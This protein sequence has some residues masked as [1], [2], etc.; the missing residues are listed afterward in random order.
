MLAEVT[1]IKQRLTH[2]SA[3]PKDQALSLNHML[4]PP[5]FTA[6]TESPET[7]NALDSHPLPNGLPHELTAAIFSAAQFVVNSFM[8]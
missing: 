4:R 2:T 1:S 5:T 6:T 7:S 3:I 8:A